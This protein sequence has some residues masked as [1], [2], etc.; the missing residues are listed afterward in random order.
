MTIINTLNI[1][2][3][4]CITDLE[5]KASFYIQWFFSI[6][7]ALGLVLSIYYFVKYI[8]SGKT[9]HKKTVVTYVILTVILIVLFI[10]VFSATDVSFQDYFRIPPECV[11]T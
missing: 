6:L 5:A 11:N 1:P 2:F 8:K 10:I 4:P 9:L 7:I 3:E